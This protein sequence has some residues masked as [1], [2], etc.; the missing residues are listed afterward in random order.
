[1][2]EQP[3]PVPDEFLKVAGKHGN[4][5][6]RFYDPAAKECS[7]YGNRPIACG[8][9]DCTS[10]EEILAI[11]GKDLLTRFDLIATD[12]PLL[13]LV[14]DHENQCPCPDFLLL[15]EQL[16]RDTQATLEQLTQVVRLDLNI[17]ATAARSKDL[18]VELEMFYFGRP[19]F[20]LLLPFDIAL[21]ETN[22]GVSLHCITE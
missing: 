16:A 3:Q 1:M 7:I 13:A 10:P 21:S 2:A 8:L 15:P 17:R 12:D 20:Q 4:W 9:F 11:T 18:S 6:C 19:L 5:C 14:T 22:Q